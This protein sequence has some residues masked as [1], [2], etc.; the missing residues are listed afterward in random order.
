MMPVLHER[1]NATA[2]VSLNAGTRLCRQS[3]LSSL[4]LALLVGAD[5]TW[6]STTGF[7][8][9]VAENLEKSLR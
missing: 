4:D 3:G 9:A 8:D 2:C 1:C 7:L 5:Q 6:R